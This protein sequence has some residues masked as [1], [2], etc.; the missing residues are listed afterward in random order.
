MPN[1]HTDGDT[2]IHFVKSD[3]IHMGDIFWN[4]LYPFIDVSSGGSI[5]GSI[6][7]CDRALALANPGTRIVAGHGD[8]VASVAELRE[9]REMLAT[10]AARVKRM[11]AEGRTEEQIAASDATAEFDARWGQRFLKGE[12][13][14]RLVAGDLLRKR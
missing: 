1:A 11:V 8:A 9:F 12:Q 2:I 3:V 5:E 7:A 14:R 6:A 4:G 10:I 13:F